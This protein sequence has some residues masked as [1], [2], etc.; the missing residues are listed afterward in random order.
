MSELMVSVIIPTYNHERY[1]VQA[2]NSVLMQKTQYSYEVLVGEDKSTDNTRMVLKRFEKTHPGMITVFYREHNMHTEKYSNAADLR[3]RAKGKYLIV[4][5]GD[6]FW[7]SEN[8]LEKQVTFLE[9]NPDYVAVAH[10]CSVVGENGL[11]INEKYPCCK[12]EEYTIKH[13]LKGI[14][15]GQLTTLMCRNYMRYDFF[16]TTILEK[17]LIPGDKLLFFALVTNG[18]VK[19][20]Q[21]SMSAYRHVRKQGSSY[22]A[23]YKYDFIKDEHWY[24]ELLLFA[25][26]QKKGIEYAEALYIG[27]LIHGMKKRSITYHDFKKYMRNVNKKCKPMFLFL[28]RM[29]NIHITHR[30]ASN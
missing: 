4:L 25:R 2:I 28:S 16:D 15:P 29:I 30:G 24:Y 23:N 19:C 18:K 3:R 17:H 13:F 22:S 21:E 7:V 10:N 14:Y 6:D 26:K 27:C 20:I 12:E 9:C 1:I 5:E 8:K 11:E